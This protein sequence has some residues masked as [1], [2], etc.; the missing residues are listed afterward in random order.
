M[1]MIIFFKS[2]FSDNEVNQWHLTHSIRLQLAPGDV[3]SI[4]GKNG[5]GPTGLLGTI[6]Y[7]NKFEIEKIVNTS[8]AWLCNGTPAIVCFFNDRQLWPKF[9]NIKNEACWIWGK[10]LEMGQTQFVPIQSHAI[11]E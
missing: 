11:F 5:P 3:I 9:N 2:P 6:H 4:R 10:I 1:L 8:S 7:Y